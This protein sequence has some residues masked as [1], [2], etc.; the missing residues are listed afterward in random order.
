MLH[1]TLRDFYVIERSRFKRM[2][3]LCFTTA[4]LYWLVIYAIVGFDLTSDAAVDARTLRAGQTVIYLILMTLWGVDYLREERRLK[5][6]IET[7]NG[8][9]VR[10]DAVMTADI[11]GKRLGAFSILRPKGTGKAPFI[12]PLV[13]LAGLAGAAYLIVMQYVNAIRMI[14]S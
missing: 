4:G 12:M 2:L 6:V 7:A 8:R 11:D 5:I 9:D 13:N 1:Q 10:P 14:A 3:A